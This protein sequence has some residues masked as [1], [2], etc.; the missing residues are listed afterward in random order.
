MQEG[1]S[2][3]REGEKKELEGGLGQT[4]KVLVAES[5]Q[6]P[7]MTGLCSKTFPASSDNLFNVLSPPPIW[8]SHTCNIITKSS[9]I[10]TCCC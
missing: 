3:S 1:E 2:K 5:L 7:G 6:F 10:E 4:V 8:Q 9:V